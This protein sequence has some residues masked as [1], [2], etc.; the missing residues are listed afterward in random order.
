METKNK[1][2]RRRG[3]IGGGVMQKKYAG[4]HEKNICRGCCEKWEVGIKMP[5]G[6]KNMLGGGR[7]K[8]NKKKQLDVDVIPPAI[9]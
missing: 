7:Q 8:I 9:V 1:N 3:N 5:E 6:N 4:G 2:I